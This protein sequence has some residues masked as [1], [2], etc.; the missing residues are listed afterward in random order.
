VAL[1]RSYPSPYRRADPGPAVVDAQEVAFADRVVRSD[2]RVILTLNQ[3]TFVPMPV[4]QRMLLA[5]LL[6]T[7]SLARASDSTGSVQ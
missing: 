4:L 2:M 7:R 1:P 3:G 5:S 6:E